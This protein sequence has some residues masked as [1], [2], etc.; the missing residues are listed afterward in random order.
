MSKISDY[1]KA[2]KNSNSECRESIQFE[3]NPKTLNEGFY[4]NAL[5]E[6]MNPC[7][8]ECAVDKTQLKKQISEMKLKVEKIQEA[9]KTAREI[10]Y[11]KDK[12]I[13][14]L[15]SKLSPKQSDAPIQPTTSDTSATP[16]PMFQTFNNIFDNDQLAKLRSFNLQKG[17]DSPFIRQIVQFLYSQN[18]ES[19]KIKTVCGRKNK[20][21]VSKEKMTPEKYQ[22]VEKVFAE[23]LNQFDSSERSA[24]IQRLNRLLKDAF[25]NI[26]KAE[27]MKN[28]EKKTCQNLSK[29]LSDK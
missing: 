14:E 2:S 12:K 4:Q 10:I 7:S 26:S 3:E 21:S 11:E 15:N 20:G 16:Q 27:E 24:R 9:I 25:A 18:L 13:A 19:L 5:L 28:T 29:T 17:G 6:Q 23:R 8:Y 22:T 1:Y